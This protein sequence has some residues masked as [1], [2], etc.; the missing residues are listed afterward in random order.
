MSTGNVVSYVYRELLG[1]HRFPSS[2]VEPWEGSEVV[3]PFEE[4]FTCCSCGLERKCAPPVGDS[5]HQVALK[6]AYPVMSGWMLRTIC[7]AS[8]RAWRIVQPRLVAGLTK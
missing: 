1:E 3:P 7:S 2:W 5:A 4:S 6:I 8:R